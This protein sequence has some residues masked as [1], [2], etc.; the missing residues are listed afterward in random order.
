MQKLAFIHTVPALTERFR[1]LA[2]A[3]L[4][5]WSNH[6]IVDES[7]LLDT[8]E[9][10]E[11]SEQ[12]VRR[13]TEHVQAAIDAGADAIV[14]T[15][16]TL[17]GAVDSIR[18]MTSVPL[19]R[20][21]RAMAEMAILKARRIGVLATLPTTLEPTRRLLDD[22]ASAT[23]D[24]RDIHAHLC[25]GAFAL[26]RSGDRA[27]HDAAVRAGFSELADRVDL[28]VLAQ[29]SMADAL[30]AMPAGSL[31]FLTRP[32]I[33]MADIARRLRSSKGPSI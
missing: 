23:G 3:T 19:F 11:V 13:L 26:L 33:G 2:E 28:V 25:D 10:G 9:R 15:C 31:P 5:D 27:G 1:S 20:I 21:D 17:G 7:L 32:E 18:P 6:A 16:S 14:V 22:I 30:R 8:I 24:T 12:T 4:S 29:A